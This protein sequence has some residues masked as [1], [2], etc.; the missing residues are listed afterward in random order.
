MHP[1]TCSSPSS[2]TL[3]LR[4][5]KTLYVHSKENF[6]RNR[7][8][9]CLAL[10]LIYALAWAS[11]GPYATRGS[12][13]PGAMKS[14]LGFFCALAALQRAMVGDEREMTSVKKK[15]SMGLLN[16]VPETVEPLFCSTS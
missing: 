1:P 4:I 5:D 7:L 11:A 14:F 8:S 16:A 3:H 10:E 2:S 9:S 13:L 6:I 15:S 12:F